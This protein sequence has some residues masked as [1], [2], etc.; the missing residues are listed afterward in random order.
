MLAAGAVGLTAAVNGGY[1]PT[2]WGWPTLAFL[3][4]TVLAVL[5]RDRLNVGP[6]ELA[7]VGALSCFALWTVVSISWAGTATEPVLS[8]ERVLVYVAFLA[9][10]FLVTPRRSAPLIL[11]GVLVAV[12][13]VCA[14]ALAT[15]LLPGRFETF[16]P[17]DGLQLDAPIGY[18]N[19]L[20]ILT[21]VGALVAWGLA[22]N[23]TARPARA[24]AFAAVPALLTTLYFTF[25]RG[26]WVALALGV[27]VSV[28][29]GRRRLHFLVVL[30]ASAPTAA[31]ALLV[32]AHSPAL[33]SAGAS[34]HAASAAGHRL[35]V[36][37][38]LCVA[39]AGAAGWAAPAFER[40]VHVG[41]RFQRAVSAFLIG[42]VLLACAGVVVR[43]GGPVKLVSRATASF[44][45]PLPQNGG[46]LNRRFISLSSN[47]R[48]E[49]WRVAWREVVAHPWLGGGAGSY[50]RYWHRDRRTAYEA[51]NAHNL[52]LETLAELGPL[53]L[54]LLLVALGL[55]FAAFLRV[56]GEPAA[57]AGIAAY[58]AA[59]AHAAIDW[60]WQ[61]PAVT[62]A[63]LACGGAVLITA[64]PDRAARATSGRLR[65]VALG[66]LLPLVVFAIVTQVGNS[67]LA[68]SVAALDRQDAAS[69]ARLAG[70]AQDW[71]PWSAQPWQRLGEAQLAAGDRAAARRSLRHAISLDPTDWTLWN[72]VAQADS[73]AARRDALVHA[74][75]LNPLGP[76]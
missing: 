12:T 13:A 70:R 64:R 37:V 68:G 10:L 50:E 43:A 66:L 16:P 11:A 46:D 7:A 32:A 76:G 51:R 21:V 30:A 33:R 23:A 69:A 15:R 67:A 5:M 3:L 65:G 28:A 4:V 14:Y 27:A 25:S 26:S 2:E 75:E 42:V 19:A 60:D 39:V 48:S 1:F 6:L 52:Y 9:A 56:R 49:Y 47:G 29:A 36:V 55:P 54:A 62:L 57:V 8:L 59:L 38:V 44:R 35:A 63:A 73:G 45:A 71:A 74:A 53:G 34:E 40:R 72:D 58:T 31:A 20:A 41:A 18:W 24:L 22:A 61:F 17:P